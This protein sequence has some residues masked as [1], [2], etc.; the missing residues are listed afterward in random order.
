LRRLLVYSGLA[1]GVAAC[2][3]ALHARWLD[4]KEHRQVAILVDWKEVRDLS[5]REIPSPVYLLQTLRN[6]GIQGVLYS[7]L[8]LKDVVRGDEPALVNHVIAFDHAALGEQALDELSRRGVSRLEANRDGETYTLTRPLGD[9]SGLADVE[10]GYDPTLLELSRDQSLPVFLR[11]NQDPWLASSDPLPEDIAGLI[12]TT[13]DPPGGVEA[14]PS[15]AAQLRMKSLIHL[16]I[17]FKP[18]RAAVAIAR[19]IPGATIR[20]HT[21]PTAELKDMTSGQELSRWQRAVHERACRCL[22]FRPAPTESW[23]NFLARLDA[24]RRTLLQEG[25]TLE[26]PAIQPTLYPTPR[27]KLLIQLGLAFGIA[28]LAPLLGLVMARS[29]K[30]WTAFFTVTFISLMGGLLVAAVAYGPETRFEIIPFRGIKPAIVISWL[31]SL[32]IL[33]P[34][35][36]LRQWVRQALTRLDLVLGVLVLLIVGYGIVRSGNAS[37]SLRAGSEQGVR[38]YLEKTLDV[39]PRFKEFA[40]GYPLLLVGF[41]MQRS[42]KRRKIGDPRAVI[43]LG[44]MGPISTVNTFCHLHSPL[45]LAFERSGLGILLGS[46]IGVMLYLLYSVF[47]GE[48]A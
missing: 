30:G 19:A 12:F 34:W 29:K 20:T 8:T 21:I 18:S 7:P 5:N 2:F 28:A 6:A 22:L 31:G 17:E 23:S 3:P 44:M 14:I 45:A 43:W 40:M 32:A 48:T 36:E 26:L 27:L 25:W 15:W 41:L 13:D 24:L 37:P 33:Y 42:R 46:I 35:R 4:E 16:V 11:L 38:D 39:R 47:E 10:I 9:F 1:I